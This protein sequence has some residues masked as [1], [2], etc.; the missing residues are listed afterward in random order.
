M[1]H[2]T[3]PDQT[4]RVQ[5][6]VV[7]STT[8]F[9]IPFAYFAEGDIVV[10]VDSTLKTLGALN[11][12]T[13][14]GDYVDVEGED[15][16]FGFTGGD[17][18]FNTGV[19]NCIVTIIRDVPVKRE[20]DFSP[21]G[22]FN[23]E[24]LNT[25]LDKMTAQI[26]QEE[27]SREY[28][29]RVDEFDDYTDLSLPV[30]ADRAGKVLAFDSTTGDP[31]AGP[32]SSAVQAVFD[33]IAADVYAEKAGD[34]FTGAVTFQD[35]VT[36]QSNIAVSGT[37]D[38]R[39]VATDGT[40]L[41]G[42]ESGATAD[43]TKADIDAL[44]IDADTLDGQHGSYYTGYTDTAISNLVDTA[45]ATLDTLNEL[46]AALGDDA[47]FSTTVTNS[48][49]TKVAKSGDTMTGNL[50]FGDNVYV[51]FG[52]SEDLQIYHSGTYS[53]IEEQGTGSLFIYGTD[54]RL[55]STA[56]EDYIQCVADGAVSLY[57]DS[58]VK[59]ATTSTG[60]DV[61]GNVAVSGTVDGRDIATDGTKLDGIEASADVTDT[62]NVTAAGALMDSEVTNLA[63]VK[64]FDSADYATAAQG[65]TADSAMQDLVDDTTPQLGGD[66][67]ANGFDI[68]F[69]DYTK[70]IFGAD[71][72]LEIRTGSYY[73]AT[74]GELYF[75]NQGYI[76]VNSGNGFYIRHGL[77]PVGS[78]AMAD[79]LSD[80][81]V[82]LYYDG[83]LKFQTSDTGVTVTG[84]AA[85]DGVTVDGI[86]TRAH[87]MVMA[88]LF[89]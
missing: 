37:V 73:S 25:E 14:D 15:A 82:K 19:S 36:V 46:A 40:K 33:D 28:M 81:A 31:I 65:T 48:I 49:A 8:T 66:L 20:T 88:N 69:G 59:L 86:D 12:Y 77:G 6:E 9:A 72:D 34:T 42:I 16:D 47:N 45:P 55:G 32:D 68:T 17:V 44:N 76:T 41:D 85:T 51:R 63:Q 60:V 35:A 70:A 26:Q 2:I 1:A 39:D 87:A 24:A 56:G 53:I 84:T 3:I 18:V 78:D 54:L 67:D 11:D 21:T 64:A 62:A 52:A 79:F 75:T 29:L 83:S 43:Q 30:K 89:G 80:G 71:N 27:T 4:A 22:Q 5:Y 7:A 13:I 61:T 38:G 10:Y 58:T 23:I 74:W 50:N 57:Y